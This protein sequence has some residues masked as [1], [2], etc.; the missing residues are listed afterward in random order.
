MQFGLAI[1]NILAMHVEEFSKMVSFSLLGSVQ[2]NM[3]S[4]SSG[5]QTHH[6][7]PCHCESGTY[8]KPKH[9]DC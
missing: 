6:A 8:D 9:I 2:N 4:E 3:H 7:V 5:I 1:I